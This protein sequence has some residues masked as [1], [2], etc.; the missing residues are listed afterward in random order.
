[1]IRILLILVLALPFLSFGQC[2]TQHSGFTYGVFPSTIDAATIQKSMQPGLLTPTFIT[3]G[4]PIQFSSIGAVAIADFASDEWNSKWLSGT[5]PS[6]VAP[7]FDNF[8]LVDMVPNLSEQIIWAQKIEV[9]PDVPHNFSVDLVN[10]AEPGA[11]AATLPDVAVRVYDGRTQGVELGRWQLPEAYATGA[12]VACNLEWV[13]YSAKELYFKPKMEMENGVAKYYVTITV[14]GFDADI[15]GCDMGIDNICLEPIPLADPATELSANDHCEGEDLVASLLLSP[16]PNS[17]SWW[18]NGVEMKDNGGT[19]IT[20]A[21]LNTASHSNLMGFPAGIH[22]VKVTYD[23]G[24]SANDPDVLY[25]LFEVTKNG[26]SPAYLEYEIDHAGD[27]V[28]FDATHTG[29]SVKFFQYNHVDEM[30]ADADADGY[31][32]VSSLA[33]NGSEILAVG[34]EYSTSISGMA[35]NNSYYFCKFV[36]HSCSSTQSQWSKDCAMICPDLSTPFTLA[37]NSTTYNT[38]THQYDVS[39]NLTDPSA[40][41]GL[42]W[43]YGDNNT[44]DYSGTF[45][46]PS[47]LTQTHSYD[48]PGFYELCVVGEWFEECVEETCIDLDICE[49]IASASLT[50]E[51]ICFGETPIA[52][53]A[54]PNSVDEAGTTYNWLLNG[55]SKG[56]AQVYTPVKEDFS[57]AGLYVVTLIKN[58][59]CTTL[60][61]TANITV[62]EEMVF[63]INWASEEVNGFDVMISA[64][65]QWQ[66]GETYNWYIDFNDTQG[67]KHM[68]GAQFQNKDLPGLFNFSSYGPGEYKIKL[69]IITDGSDPCTWTSEKI[70]CVAATPKDCCNCAP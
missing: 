4:D 55:V 67:Y 15:I 34:G 13:T 5:G 35:L 54:D 58:N 44:E 38:S 33:V 56:T 70:I 59:G 19:P 52:L 16:Q 8:Y 57:Q 29:N 63:G 22:T 43:V 65:R 42:H 14:V 45:P 60:T 61:E 11:L 23:D 20:T 3:H 47:A 9:E 1:M 17:I 6:G 62:E 21:T 48:A 18:V 25:Q 68:N 37:H 39:I 53:D 32:D 64:S 30:D 41:Q 12:N 26:S 66:S 46:I 40:M 28:V 27:K 7:N 10:I 24:N 2:L 51:P 49:S 31:D 36:E 50:D 69:E